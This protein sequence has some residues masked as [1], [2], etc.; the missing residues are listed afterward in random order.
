MEVVI[1][2]SIFLHGKKVKHQRTGTIRTIFVLEEN[3]TPSGNALKKGYDPITCILF[4]TYIAN[5]QFYNLLH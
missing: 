2:D 1:T 5:I 3:D 4:D